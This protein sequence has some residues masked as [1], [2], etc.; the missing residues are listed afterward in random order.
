MTDSTEHPENAP[1]GR[2]ER[3]KADKRRRIEA[4]AKELFVH[5]GFSAVTTHE[6]ARRAEVGTGTLFRYAQSKGELLCLVANEE[7]RD[8]VG[9]VPDTGDVVS[10]FMNLCRPFLRVLRVQPDNAVAYHRETIFGEPGPHREE[11]LRILGELRNTIS[12]ILSRESGRAA[13]DSEIRAAAYTVFDVIYMEIVRAGVNPRTH[14]NL[15][16][17]FRA[18][19]ERVVHGTIPYLTRSGQ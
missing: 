1:G 19:I 18:H 16:A 6:V 9:V 7:F 17:I 11:A 2:R 4:A 12:T 3:N 13:D 5:R 14:S 8:L 15:E 10:D